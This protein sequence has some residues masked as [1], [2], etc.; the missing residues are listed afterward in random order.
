[1]FGLYLP[2]SLTIA[3]GSWNL[4]SGSVVSSSSRD[5]SRTIVESYQQER[6]QS[7]SPAQLCEDYATKVLD[8]F[9]T[10]SEVDVC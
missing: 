4:A 2:S 6:H 7:D 1:M 9:A 10:I 3:S 8:Y 5:I